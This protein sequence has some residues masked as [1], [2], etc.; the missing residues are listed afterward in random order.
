M[1]TPARW[2]GRTLL[3]LG[4][5]AAAGWSMA[6]SYPTVALEDAD[7][8]ADPARTS[9]TP[10]SSTLPGSSTPAPSASSS[11]A[12]SPDGGA[13]T[14]DGGSS[15]PAEVCAD[16]DLS[17]CFAFDGDADD[18][19]PNKVVPTATSG[20]TF[21]P[22]RTGQAALFGDASF[23]RF[24]SAPAVSTSKA[25]VEAWINPS[26]R[27]DAIIFDANER[28]ALAVYGNGAMGCIAQGADVRGGTLETG[29]WSH[30]ACVFDGTRVRA[31]LDGVLVGSGNG[32][33]G[34]NTNASV[35]IGGNAPTGSPF[36]GAIDSFRVFR[37]ARNDQQIVD[38]AA[39]P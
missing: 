14:A 2:N 5:A 16:A 15:A 30:V 7:A 12:K 10:S 6:C 11:P 34:S 1:K 35:A 28:Y 23:L 31:F 21:V 25:T 20:L 24:T 39:G 17:L 38:D 4:F 19:S 22:G 9:E 26:L 33:T 32:N 29:K 3:A 37:T 18:R 36:A 27:R 8:G 13:P